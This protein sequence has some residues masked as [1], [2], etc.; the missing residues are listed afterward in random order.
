VAAALRLLGH[1]VAVCVGPN[2]RGL[3]AD[4]DAGA[5]VALPRLKE[6]SVHALGGA[7]AD[8]DFALVNDTGVL[9][10]AAA[11][12]TAVL[13]LFGPTD[14]DVWCPSAARVWS[15]RAPDGR[16]RSLATS[17]VSRAAAAL[18]SHLQGDGRPPASVQP[19][20]A[21]RPPG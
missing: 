13:A 21:P 12:G 15:M 2:E 7:L 14:P 10:L 6:L 9:H 17:A 4:V 5:G 3:L 16:M 11:T 8:A 20:P 19:A 18:A 1:R